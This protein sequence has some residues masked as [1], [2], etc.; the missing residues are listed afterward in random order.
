MKSRT[1]ALALFLVIPLFA[2][3]TIRYTS[4][5]KTA[6]S[7]AAGQIPEASLAALNRPSEI[8][9]KGNKAYQVLGKFVSITD[10]T[11]NEV[12]FIDAEGM[13]FGTT[14][15]NQI[16]GLVA[17]ALPQMPPQAKSFADMVKTEVQS[18]KTGR[19]EKIHGLDAEE[20]E[21]TVNININMPN[22]P[23]T[24]G[25]G[26]TMKVVMQV[27]RA[28]Q[29]EIAHNPALTEFV[30]YSNLTA[31]SMDPLAALR[32]LPGPM[33]G[34]SESFRPVFEEMSRDQALLLRTHMEAS[35]P[36]MSVLMPQG[37]PGIDPNAPLMSSD[38]EI[39]ELSADP[40]DESIFGVPMGYKKVEIEEI[41]KDQVSA[42]LGKA[43]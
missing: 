37:A 6:F 22:L 28:S 8:R 35:S 14:Q 39:A 13:R 42:M 24:P 7:L 20:T 21:V 1:A 41:F 36:M 30:K 18:R 2:D 33:Q 17:K 11:T 43:Q 38:Q 12:T 34:L 31:S 26:P 27:W 9:I 3:V 4:S 5:Y 32:Q 25:S 10:L 16:A 19:M 29:D 40:V 15:A 23:N